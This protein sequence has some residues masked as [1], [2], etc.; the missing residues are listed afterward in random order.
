MHSFGL[1][2][3]KA[4]NASRDE[5]ALLREVLCVVPG[6]VGSLCCPYC[7]FCVVFLWRLMAMLCC[8]WSASLR[9]AAT[10][11]FRVFAD[12]SSFVGRVLAEQGT[13]FF[14]FFFFFPVMPCRINR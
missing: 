13:L 5:Y 2:S 7:R 3:R 4:G 9:R 6:W 12:S 14:F 1:L 10:S 11:L 8:E